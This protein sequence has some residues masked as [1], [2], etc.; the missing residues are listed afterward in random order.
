MAQP[1][2]WRERRCD[3]FAVH[4]KLERTISSASRHAKGDDV[5]A[6]DLGGCRRCTALREVT[7]A[8]AKY[9]GLAIDLPGDEARV[10]QLA[11]AQRAIETVPRKIDTLVAQA[12]VRAKFRM[13]CEQLRDHWYHHLA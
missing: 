8:R 2:P 5:V 1:H 9:E 10:R 6:R 12:K 3:G 13:P 4:A 11:E 7:R